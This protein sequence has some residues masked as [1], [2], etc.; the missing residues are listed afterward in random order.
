[1]RVGKRESTMGEES[2]GEGGRLIGKTEEG[3]G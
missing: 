2:G 1:M 3:R